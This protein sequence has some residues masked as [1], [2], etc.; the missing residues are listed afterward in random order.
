MLIDIED[1]FLTELLISHRSRDIIIF[2]KPFQSG[3]RFN[4]DKYVV[5]RFVRNYEDTMKR[6]YLIGGAMGVGKT[7]VCQILK[8]RLPNSVF[9][10]GD[11]CWDMHPFQVTEET[12]RMVTDNICFLLD[13]FLRCS[14][15]ENIIFCWVM[16]EQSII[17]GILSRLDVGGSE[18][19]AIS[20]LCDEKSLK[21]RLQKDVDAGLR[22]A[23]VIERSIARLPLYERL[24]TVKLDVS[25]LSPEE[26]A[27]CICQL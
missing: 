19:K 7:T 10:D 14:A 13:Q 12:K 15:Y 18:V 2:G 27:E 20:L 6:L 4:W 5:K 1:V 22:E 9:L 8:K 21:G 24:D 25:D 17:D 16:H 23:D 26:T 3:N 11:W